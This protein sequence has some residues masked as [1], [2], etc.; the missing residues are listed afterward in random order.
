MS[1]LLRPIQKCQ[2]VGVVALRSGSSFIFDLRATVFRRSKCCPPA[3]GG[4]RWSGNLEA[5]LGTSIP[6]GPAKLLLL[7]CLLVDSHWIILLRTGARLLEKTF[8]LL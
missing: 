6:A 7:L 2:P 1:A 4:Y 3:S 5:F 8:N